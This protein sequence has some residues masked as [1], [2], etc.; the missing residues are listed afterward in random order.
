M[1]WDKWIKAFEIFKKYGPESFYNF[2]HEEAYFGPRTDASE[3][4][5][6]DV[7]KL[8]ELGF[9]VSEGSFLMLS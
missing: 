3:M 2:K 6:E 8:E 9:M 5:D 1:T 4:A 7:K